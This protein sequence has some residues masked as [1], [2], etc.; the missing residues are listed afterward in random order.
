M[1]GIT[2]KMI[3]DRCDEVGDCWEWRYA[4]D[5]TAPVMRIPGMRK[6]VAVRRVVLDLSG[7]GVA[8]RL[9]CASC[10]NPRC[11]A[12]QHAVAL[13]RQQLQQRTAQVTQ[14]GRSRSRNAKLSHARRL[15]SSMTE[16]AVA[17]MRSS[18]LS[19]RAAAVAFGCS[20]TAAADIM[21]FR[22]WKDY[23]SP[24]LGLGGR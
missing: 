1:H 21:A 16:E 7:K 15:R 11:V 2:L 13:T 8:G 19:T 14:Y 4:L 17:Q 24:F 5:G 22:T 20:Q 9:A 12:P 18:G 3:H 10:C 23:S 6:L